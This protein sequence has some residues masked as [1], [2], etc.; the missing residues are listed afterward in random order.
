MLDYSKISEVK[1]KHEDLNENLLSEYAFDNRVD[2]KY[3]AIKVGNIIINVYTDKDD[4][5]HENLN[6]SFK[7]ICEI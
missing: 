1:L 3:R 2:E 4:V 6:T 5:Y 7:N